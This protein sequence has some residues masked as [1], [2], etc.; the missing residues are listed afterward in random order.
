VAPVWSPDSRTL[1][2]NKWHDEDKAT[3]DIYLLDL[4][5]LKMSKKF[6]NTP[7]VFAWVAAK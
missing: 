7:P 2:I 6:G 1:L 5:T 4:A 3:M